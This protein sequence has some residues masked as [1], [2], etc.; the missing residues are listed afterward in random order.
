MIDY[1]LSYFDKVRERFGG[2]D[3]PEFLL[4]YSLGG[5]LSAKLSVVSS[6]KFNGMGLLSPYIRMLNNDVMTKYLPM[7]KLAT[8]VLPNIRLGNVFPTPKIV[9]RRH[10]HI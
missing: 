4:G 8:K 5:I 2:K 3:V 10:K 7:A 6:H 9:S 1:H